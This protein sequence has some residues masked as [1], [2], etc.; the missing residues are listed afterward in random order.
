MAQS[1]YLADAIISPHPRYQT[2]TACIRERKGNVRGK[3]ARCLPSLLSA[4]EGA[5]GAMHQP[6]ISR[7]KAV[8]A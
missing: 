1:R 7:K 8:T 3:S 6:V 4:E 2:M 5:E